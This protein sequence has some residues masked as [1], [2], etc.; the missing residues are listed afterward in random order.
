MLSKTSDEA[1][2]VLCASAMELYNQTKW[3]LEDADHNSWD[4]D[5]DSGS[6]SDDCTMNGI[7]ELVLRTKTYTA[8]LMDLSSALICPALEVEPKDEPS[9]ITSG[10][11]CAHDYHAR[12][13]EAKFPRAQP[14]LLHTL[15]QISW[16]RYQRMQQEREAYFRAQLVISS[17]QNSQAAKSQFQDSGIGSSL[18]IASTYAGTTISFTTMASDGNRLNIPSIPAEAKN[19]KSFECVACGRHV[20]VTNNRE[21]R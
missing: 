3:L 21:W 9:V 4:N 1:V 8:C 17:D 12:L 7:H 10:Q 14:Q 19:G 16:K 15:G 18:P 13:I 20:R 5:T 11:R 2:T 6:S